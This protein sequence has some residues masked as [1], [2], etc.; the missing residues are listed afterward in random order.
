MKPDVLLVAPRTNLLSVDA[1]VQAILRS[2][3]NVTPM[4]GTVEHDDL[5]NEMQTPKRVLWLCTH[6][7][8]EGVLLSDGIL[9]ASL[10][11]SLARDTFD[12]IVLNTC[13]SIGTAQMLQNETGAEIIATITETPDREAFQTGAI[14][15][16]ALAQTNGDSEAAYYRAKPGGNRTYVRL[17]G[18]KKL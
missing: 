9:E 14:F 13:D 18:K 12:L 11:T 8:K 7:S 5:V 4:L 2:G 17:A 10:L 1:E 6:G 15:A 16:R 3:L